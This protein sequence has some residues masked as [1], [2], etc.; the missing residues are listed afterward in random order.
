MTTLAE[1]PRLVDDGAELP[2]EIGLNVYR[3]DSR[4]W[5]FRLWVDADK[6]VPYDLGQVLSATAQVRR[7]PDDWTAVVLRT[8]ITLPNWV[9]CHLDAAQSAICPTGRWDLQ[10][11]F[12]G[13]RVLTVVR[14]PVTVTPDVTR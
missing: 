12:P 5:A 8:Q 1:A 4:S 9:F 6:T 3:G 13:G 7:E 11:T 2:A 14:G 10:L